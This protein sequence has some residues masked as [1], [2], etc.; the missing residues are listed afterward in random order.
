MNAEYELT[1][2]AQD[3]LKIKFPPRYE[4][5]LSGTR[6]ISSAA[7]LIEHPTFGIVGRKDS[8]TGIELLIV[9]INGSVTAPDGAINH[10]VWSVENPAEITEQAETLLNDAITR[11]VMCLPFEIE[12]T[13]T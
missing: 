6:L 9:S 5:V 4:N 13:I 10:I 2:E 12:A 8:G 1:T 3:L 7:D 11:Y